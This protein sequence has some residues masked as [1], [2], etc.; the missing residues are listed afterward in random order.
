MPVS[1]RLQ[2]FLQHLL[3]IGTGVFISLLLLAVLP[4][5]I[6]KVTQQ[7]NKNALELSQLVPLQEEEM[8]N[9]EEPPDPDLPDPP[10]PEMEPPAPP[11]M[12]PPD[13]LP[14]EDVTEP[15]ATEEIPAIA[16]ELEVPAISSGAAM[17]MAMK[18][19]VFNRPLATPRMSP[20][21][22]RNKRVF[23]MKEVDKQPQYLSPMQP[24]YPYKAR[25]MGIEG[26][27]D[28][29]FLVDRNGLVHK[30]KIL[31]ARPEGEFEETVKKT[32]PHWKFKP[33]QKNGRPVSTWV[34]T[35]ILFKLN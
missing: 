21:A 7:T 29:R 28:V 24:P 26:Y 33:G 14:P 25:R 4:L 15:V 16:L 35:R 11:E 18:Q 22:L 27:V 23:D 2:R 17:S 6:Q 3:E 31:R 12:E 13:M 5:L 32:V 1:Q 30:L 8:V 20:P 9:P 19:P 10:Q 34:K